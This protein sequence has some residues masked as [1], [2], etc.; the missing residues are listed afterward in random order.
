MGQLDVGLMDGFVV[1][2]LKSMM[3]AHH[4]PGSSKY[5]MKKVLKIG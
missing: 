5:L 4:I 2:Q 3:L 1:T